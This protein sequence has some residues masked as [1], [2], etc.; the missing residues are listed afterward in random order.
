MDRIILQ[1][2][3]SKTLKQQAEVAVRDQGFSSVQEV[4]R[5]LLTKLARHE[6]AV[7]VRYPE[8]HL[9]PHT[10]RRYAKIIRDIKA[11]KNITKTNS[12]NELFSILES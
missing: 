12:L 7:E 6:L 11:G 10:E 8:E 3:M 1:V 2:P 5:V 9:S 4:I